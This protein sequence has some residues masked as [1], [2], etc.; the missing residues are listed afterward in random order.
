MSRLPLLLLL[1]LAAA[2]PAIA[3]DDRAVAFETDRQWFAGIAGATSQSRFNVDSGAGGS[4][5]SLTDAALLRVGR[6]GRPARYGIDL[7]YLRYDEATAVFGTA[8]LDY[9]IAAG[10]IFSGY[11]GIAAGATSVQWRGNDPFDAGRNF[12]VGGK[13]EASWAAG[14]R[15]GGLIEVTRLVQVELGYRFLFT[16]LEAEFTDGGNGSTVHMRNQRAVHAGV[17]FR[18]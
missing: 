11:L 5:N 14:L 4:I 15:I 13:R 6:Y 1:S 2:A 18:F 10:D 3:S 17:N 12:S 7:M 9:I 8:W 16:G